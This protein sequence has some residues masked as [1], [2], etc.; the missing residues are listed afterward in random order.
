MDAAQ[1]AGRIA[2]INFV[3]T[4]RLIHSLKTAIA[5]S[6]A[7]L[8]TRAIGAPADQWVV[9]SVI[10]VMCAQI[11]VG[12]IM[13]KS[14]LRLL[15]TLLGCLTATLTII[16]FNTSFIAILCTIA[17]AS[18]IFSF[19]A[20]SRE[21]LSQMGTLGAVTTIIILFGS[22]PSLGFAGMRF[23]EISVG[24]LIAALVSQF[25][26]PIHARTHLRR[27]QAVTLGQIRD[28][29]Q[30]AMINRFSD[31]DKVSSGDLDEIIIKSMLKQRQLAKEA[32]PELIGK[33][34]D[35]DHFARSLYCE[36]EIL[37]AINFMDMAL[38]KMESIQSIY[39]TPN[40]LTPFNQAV[41]AA[42]EVL[43]RV[44]KTNNLANAH[45]HVPDLKPMTET[46]HQQSLLTVNNQ[47]I[48]LD[49]FIFSAEILV[50]NLHELALLYKIPVSSEPL[51][52]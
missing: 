11:Y 23:L 12:G 36:R 19:I 38:S 2:I 10:V 42:L 17:I 1:L 3:A 25:I 4:E 47:H 27:S 13:Q 40:P 28:Y 9:I 46:L 32:A 26:F 30:A 45:I 6:G 34:F 49:G 51:P 16:F 7:Y 52:A 44:L 21:D 50:Q 35:P 24:I 41:M 39:S 8:L 5:C 43:I 37:R 48:Y 33:R 22:P 31:P 20:T 29:Y 18:F 15:G 14:Y